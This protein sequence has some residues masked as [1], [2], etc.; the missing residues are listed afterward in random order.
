MKINISKILP[1][2]LSTFFVA[3]AVVSLAS[4]FDFGKL[5]ANSYEFETK[6][7]IYAVLVKDAQNRQQRV[8][9][10]GEYKK[11]WFDAAKATNEIDTSQLPD[12]FQFAWKKYVNAQTEVAE[13][14][15]NL[16]QPLNFNIDCEENRNWYN[17]YSEQTQAWSEVV[18]IAKNY[19]LKF[20]Q[21]ENLIVD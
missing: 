2:F 18:S 16:P 6:Q 20:D 4:Y 5:G 10:T 12:D 15:S 7:K 17:A 21:Y 11:V 14:F 9:K 8:E 1:P 19:G 3:V 13:A